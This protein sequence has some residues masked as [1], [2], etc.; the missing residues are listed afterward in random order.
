ML[1][2]KWSEA[3]NAS[4]I[5]SRS[6]EVQRNGVERRVVEAKNGLDEVEKRERIE[7]P[8]E[9]EGGEEFEERRE[10]RF[11]G[12]GREV[13]TCEMRGD[14]QDFDGIDGSV[15]QNALESE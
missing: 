14:L 2:W 11:G 8:V 9:T 6:D 4:A 10:K 1:R 12:G 3:C 7:R 5:G 13:E 15:L